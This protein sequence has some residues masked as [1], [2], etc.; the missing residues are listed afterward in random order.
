MFKLWLLRLKFRRK[1][2]G[3]LKIDRGREFISTALQNLYNKK[4]I[5]IGYTTSYM[6]E[7]NDIAKQC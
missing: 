5:D 2:L 3:C 4:K 7:E 6:Y 1:K